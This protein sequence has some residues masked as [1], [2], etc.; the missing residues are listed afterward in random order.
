MIYIKFKKTIAEDVIPLEYGNFKVNLVPMAKNGIKRFVAYHRNR[1]AKINFLQ[2]LMSMGGMNSE[3]GTQ[4]NAHVISEMLGIS[5]RSISNYLK[6]LVK[7]GFIKCLSRKYKIGVKSRTYRVDNQYLH[8]HIVTNVIPL[9]YKNVTKKDGSIRSELLELRKFV[10]HLH[11]NFKQRKEF[12]TKITFHLGGLI[13]K[14]MKKIMTAHMTYGT[15]RIKFNDRRFFIK[16][17]KQLSAL[18]Q[19]LCA[20]YGRHYKDLLH[21]LTHVVDQILLTLKSKI[22]DNIEGFG[23]GRKRILNFI[24]NIAFDKCK[25]NVRKSGMKFNLSFKQFISFLGVEG[26]YYDK[27]AKFFEKFKPKMDMMPIISQFNFGKFIKLFA[28][29]LRKCS[30]VNNEYRRKALRY[31]KQYGHVYEVFESEAYC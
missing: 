24:A 16:S 14:N 26:T 27:K 2:L 21:D 12:F 13:L 31:S 18:I 5:Q 29:V 10:I 4:I 15:N 25:Y 20:F 23:I 6:S 17:N 22:G 7:L 19:K 30:F 1:P 11:K 3:Q 28:I 9:N 8:F